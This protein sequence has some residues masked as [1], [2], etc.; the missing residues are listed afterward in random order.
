M[1][2][3]VILFALAVCAGAWAQGIGNPAENASLEKGFVLIGENPTYHIPNLN[4][5]SFR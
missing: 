1:K 3:M 4:N 2:K 5:G